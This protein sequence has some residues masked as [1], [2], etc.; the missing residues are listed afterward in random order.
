MASSKTAPVP[1]YPGTI[2]PIHGHPAWKHLSGTAM[3]KANLKEPVIRPKEP[4]TSSKEAAAKAVKN[5]TTRA[6]V[7]DENASKDVTSKD[8]VVY[9]PKGNT[10]L[11]RFSD[12]TMSTKRASYASTTKSELRNS[13]QQMFEMLQSVQ[14]ELAT[15]RAILSDIQSRLSFLEHDAPTMVESC[16]PEVLSPVVDEL[17]PPERAPPS[18]PPKRASLVIPP[19]RESQSWWQM[20][21]KF[22]EN[23]DTPCDPQEF[24]GKTPSRFED[25]DFHFGGLRTHD[26]VRPVTPVELEIDN[27]PALSPASE[28]HPS[29]DA[30]LEA[31]EPVASERQSSESVESRSP[32]IFSEGQPRLSG[33]TMEHC[34]EID[35]IIEQVVE[36]KKPAA[37]PPLLLHPPR[38]ARTASRMSAEEIT[39]L[40]D[41]PP[42]IEVSVAPQ[43]Y[44]K[45]IRS[46]STKWASLKGRT[47]ETSYYRNGI[48]SMR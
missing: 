9:L 25:F 6:P 24:L 31:E 1:S 46:I 19:G 3:D 36:F 7:V 4:A 44:R 38:S 21:Q 5:L 17:K 39:A 30:G 43:Q 32:S 28:R 42:V 48:F 18:P 13:N 41:C 20:C 22:A 47:N 40:P 12:I 35:N 33:L 14:T 37:L 10:T 26:S 2:L 16:A 8:D 15:H 29:G 27:V 11:N 45:G 34:E 23:C